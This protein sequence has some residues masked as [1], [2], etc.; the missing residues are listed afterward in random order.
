MSWS[1][2][3][4]FWSFHMTKSYFLDRDQ[5]P[6][7]GQKTNKMVVE[8]EQINFCNKSQKIQVL[9]RWLKCTLFRRFDN[10]IYQWVG[11]CHNNMHTCMCVS[12]YCVYAC[13]GVPVWESCLNASCGT[14]AVVSVVR[15]VNVPRAYSWKSTWNRPRAESVCVRE[16]MCECTH[17]LRHVFP[18]A[19]FQDPNFPTFPDVLL[20]K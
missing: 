1:L 15:V 14:V 19:R 17:L 10:L 3:G 11:A 7:H 12:M 16:W 4:Q 5:S 2:R 6:A 13:V 8:E 9:H 20:D 18:P